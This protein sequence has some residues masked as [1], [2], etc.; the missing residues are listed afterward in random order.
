M[1]SLLGTAAKVGSQFVHPSTALLGCVGPRDH[2]N[3][4]PSP[5]PRQQQEQPPTAS[6]LSSPAE[7][8]RG[9]EGARAVAAVVGG[10]FDELYSQPETRIQLADALDFL[11]RCVV[12]GDVGISAGRSTGGNL[13]TMHLTPSIP[14]ETISGRQVVHRGRRLRPR[15][16]Q[17]G[18]AAERGRG[19]AR[20]VVF[21]LARHVHGAGAW[22]ENVSEA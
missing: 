5:P 8:Q 10:I 7:A 15:A 18:E 2:T 17:E 22:L 20:R 14:H 11:V 1:A 4:M 6:T 19:R 9:E 21:H 16:R 3:S 13:L 12:R